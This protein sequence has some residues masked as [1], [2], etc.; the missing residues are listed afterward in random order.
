MVGGLSL[1]LFAG[2]NEKRGYC[3]YTHD[4]SDA[5]PGQ[6]LGDL[7]ELDAGADVTTWEGNQLAEEGMDYLPDTWVE[8]WEIVVECEAGGERQTHYELMGQ[9][10]KDEF[11]G[12]RAA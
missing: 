11:G 4:Y 7:K 12:E 1:Y 6:L 5:A 9:A 3:V 2:E 8:G 10:A